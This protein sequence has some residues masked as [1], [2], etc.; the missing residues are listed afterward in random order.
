MQRDEVRVGQ[1]V[2]LVLDEQIPQQV[3]RHRPVSVQATGTV[4]AVDEPGLPPGVRVTLDREI[5]G[6]DTCYAT[7]RELHPQRP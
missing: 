2:W 1:Q 4:T 5:N 6:V 7:Y 3:P